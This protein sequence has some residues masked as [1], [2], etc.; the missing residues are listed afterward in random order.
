M[1]LRLSQFINMR[2]DLL[3]YYCQIGDD[4]SGFAGW[5]V[6]VERHARDFMEAAKKLQS[7]FI[8]MQREDQ[9]T[10]EDTLRKVCL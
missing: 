3:C 8:G 4:D 5:T 2:F 1:A 7:Y 9:P 6:D 10:N